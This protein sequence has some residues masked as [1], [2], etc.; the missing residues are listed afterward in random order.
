MSNPYLPMGS[1]TRPGGELVSAIRKT[2][3]PVKA[4]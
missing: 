4:S 1:T 3:L 2:F